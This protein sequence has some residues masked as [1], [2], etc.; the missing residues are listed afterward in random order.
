MSTA[1][2]HLNWCV[3]RALAEYDRGEKMDAIASFMSD[4]SKDDRTAWIKT[5]TTMSML[6][7]AARVSRAEFEKAMTGFNV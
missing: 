5:S 1:R 7:T 6:F 2:D 3:A 4:V